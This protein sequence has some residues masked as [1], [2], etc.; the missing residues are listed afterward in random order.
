MNSNSLRSSVPSRDVAGKSAVV[1]RMG[2]SRQ[3]QDRLRRIGDEK[4]LADHADALAPMPG[5]NLGRMGLK[6]GSVPL[7]A[8]VLSMRLGQFRRVR[9][10]FHLDGR[11]VNSDHSNLL[12]VGHLPRL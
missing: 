5:I 8:L 10:L 1:L 4:F 12:L 2:R 7:E 3:G 6:P 9:Y 11:L